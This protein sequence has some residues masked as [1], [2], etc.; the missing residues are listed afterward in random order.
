M[1]NIDIVSYNG[2]TKNTVLPDQ[3]QNSTENRKNRAEIDTLTHIYITVSFPMPGTDTSV[4]SG[5]AKL[6]L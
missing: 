6:V 4:K 5:G 3:F 1:R 2:K